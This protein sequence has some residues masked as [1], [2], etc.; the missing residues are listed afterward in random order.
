MPK[1]IKCCGNTTIMKNKP[2]IVYLGAFRFPD[3]DAAAKR[4][5]G[6]GH[7]LRDIGYDVV[8]A[9]GETGEIGKK[10]YQ[11]F[12]Y[13]SQNELDVPAI[14]GV[15]KIKKLFASG[16]NT[17]AWLNQYIK[18]H[19]VEKVI[20]YNSSAIFIN[21]IRRFCKVNKIE[22]LA[23]I[24]EWYDSNHLPGGKYGPIGIDNY[25]KMNY[26]YK[27]IPKHIAISTYLE[28]YYNKNTSVVIPPLLFGNYPSLSENNDDAKKIIYVGSPGKKDNLE[29]MI[30]AYLAHQQ[31]FE[32]LE[33]VIAGITEKEYNNLYQKKLE[34][35]PKINFLGR[36][37]PEAVTKLYSNAS[38]SFFFRPNERYANA[39]FPT[40]FVESL[41]FGVPV[42]TNATS[43]I[44]TYLE[45]DENGFLVEN[46]NKDSI[47]KILEKIND[48]SINDINAMKKKSLSS[49][50]VFYFKKFTETTRNFL[51]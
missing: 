13:Y 46:L 6:I 5:L 3:K 18:N 14:G 21:K 33:F 31:K 17:L 2:I 23:D 12:A 51:Y 15:A 8:F 48:L 9:G 25:L 30:E 39:G 20:V 35:S 37:S 49:A 40:K 11:E 42:I 7:I 16:D 45:N 4:V 19:N 28:K 10:I 41:G 32:K 43:D 27:L 26:L 36:I 50:E 38:F 34:S 29:L 47:A 22:I 44:A 24:T 1:R